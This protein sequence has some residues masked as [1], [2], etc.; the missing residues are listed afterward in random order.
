MTGGLKVLLALAL[1]LTGILGAQMASAAIDARIDVLD[2]ADIDHGESALFPI[3]IENV[4]TRAATYDVSISGTDGWGTW[5]VDPRTSVTLAPG[6]ETILYLHLDTDKHAQAGTRHVTVTVKS[7][8]QST[9]ADI[10]LYIRAPHRQGAPGWINALQG[11]LTLLLLALLILAILVAASR[12]RRRGRKQKGGR[13]EVVDID[14]DDADAPVVTRVA[15][16]KQTL[17]RAVAIEPATERKR[18]KTNY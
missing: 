10:A 15:A 6:E 8:S 3:H 5:R 9:S 17:R 11:G 4:G 7:G 2:R 18:V 13:I 12:M 1:L 14:G 16:K